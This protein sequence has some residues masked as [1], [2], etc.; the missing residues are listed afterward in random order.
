MI[1]P[2]CEELPVPGILMNPK[3]VFSF[4]R[5]QTSKPFAEAS[6]SNEGRISY[7]Q[8]TPPPCLISLNQFCCPPKS[9]ADINPDVSDPHQTIPQSKFRRPCNL[10]SL[11]LT[12]KLPQLASAYVTKSSQVR[13]GAFMLGTVARFARRCFFAR[14]MQK[15]RA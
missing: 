9:S 5:G 1:F 7:S 13:S 2:T 10:L 12:R 6:A 14:Y 8:P 11:R 15:L 3:L 4:S